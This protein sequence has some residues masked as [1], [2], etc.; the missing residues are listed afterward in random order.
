[1]A[2][3]AANGFARDRPLRGNRAAASDLKRRSYCGYSRGGLVNIL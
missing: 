3:E 2:G 1:M